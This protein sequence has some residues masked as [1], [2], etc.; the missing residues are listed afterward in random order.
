MAGAIVIILLIFAS[1]ASVYK[2]NKHEPPV[3]KEFLEDYKKL[4][5]KRVHD[6]IESDANKSLF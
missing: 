2:A 6:I 5:Q 4:A 3:T 1:T